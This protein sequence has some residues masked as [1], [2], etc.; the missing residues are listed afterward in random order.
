[1]DIRQSISSLLK[2]T[3]RDAGLTDGAT[4]EEGDLRPVLLSFLG[5]LESLTSD[6]CRPYNS[7]GL[8]CALQ[9]RIPFGISTPRKGFEPDAQIL[10][11]DA[12]ALAFRFSS[13]TEDAKVKFTP[14]DYD[15]VAATDDLSWLNDFPWAVE[16]IYALVGA[17]NYVVKSLRNLGKGAMGIPNFKSD[18]ISTILTVK[19]PSQLRQKVRKYDERVI[20]NADVLMLYGLPG[21]VSEARGPLCYVVIHP[22]WSE[23]RKGNTSPPPKAQLL[24]MQGLYAATTLHDQEV[25]RIFGSRVYVEDLFAFL[26][27]LFEPLIEKVHQAERF[28]GQGYTF[29]QEED[30]IKYIVRRAPDVYAHCYEQLFQHCYPGIILECFTHEYWQEVAPKLL[31]FISHDFE[32]RHSIDCQLFRPK[33]FAY[34]CDCGAIFLHLGSVTHF[35]AHLWDGFEPTGDFHSIKGPIFEE[36]LLNLLESIEGFTRIWDTGRKLKFPVEGKIGTDIDVFIRRKELAFLI[37]C[38]SYSINRKYEL[39]DGQACWDRSETAKSWFRFAYESVKVI[40]AH[41]QELHIPP[42]IE[43]IC[44]LVC[45]GWPEYLHE[46]SEQYYMEDGTPR[47]ATIDEIRHFFESMDDIKANN[48]L[49]DAYTVLINS[50]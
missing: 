48:L 7:F 21:A 40:A 6:V 11:N 30:L 33:R 18:D 38:K 37:S 45:T 15:K 49:H 12:A 19:M 28:A 27:T 44:P 9:H 10:F 17:I 47:I 41:H 34:R 25:K 20:Q 3:L 22:N 42:E 26:A 46:P 35:F 16:N 5:V 31:D 50:P 4:Y 14:A 2:N 13:S 23:F 32:S 39:G 36:L 1:M 43:G 24:N 8:L 29:S